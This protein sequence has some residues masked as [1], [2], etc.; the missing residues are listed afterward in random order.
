MA[1]PTRKKED[2]IVHVGDRVKE[3]RERLALSKSELGRILGVSG[4][5]VCEWEHNKRPVPEL[6]RK[7]ICK[8]FNVDPNWLELGVGAIF[9]FNFAEHSATDSEL[10]VFDQFDVARKFAAHLTKEIKYALYK[11]L[12]EEVG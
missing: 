10:T 11:V 1:R 5:T 7:Q 2:F 3:L 8:T 9:R 12:E 6:R 4:A